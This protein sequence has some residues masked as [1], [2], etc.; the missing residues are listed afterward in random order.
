MLFLLSAFPFVVLFL[1]F[2]MLRRLTQDSVASTMVTAGVI[3][4]CLTLI[5]TELL[6]ALGLVVQGP[7]AVSWSIVLL[8]LLWAIRAQPPATVSQ[9]RSPWSSIQVK[10]LNA[11]GFEKCASIALLTLVSA[12]GL[13]ALWVAPNNHDGLAYHLPKIMHWIQNGNVNHYPTHIP[14]QIYLSPLAEYLALQFIVI[15]SHDYFVNSIQWLAYVGTLI[16]VWELSTLLGGRRFEKQIAMVLAATMPMGILQSTTPQNDLVVSFFF[17]AFIVFGLRVVFK[18]ETENKAFLFSVLTGASLGCAILTKSTAYIFAAPFVSYFCVLMVRRHSR[19]VALSCLGLAAVTVLLVNGVNYTRLYETYGTP[20]G[21][22]AEPPDAYFPEAPIRLEIEGPSTIISSVLKNLSI[23]QIL[24]WSEPQD[25]EET[26]RRLHSLIHQDPDR[27]GTNL[28]RKHGYD[29]HDFRWNDENFAGNPL[30]VLCAFLACL[31]Y[32]RCRF[33]PQEQEAIKREDKDRSFLFLLLLSMGFLLFCCLINWQPVASRLHLPLFLVAAA[34]VPVLAGGR[35]GG[36]SRALGHAVAVILL[37]QAIPYI[38]YNNKHKAV[39]IDENSLTLFD[40]S[41]YL[42]NS[43][44]KQSYNAIIQ[45]LISSDCRE[46][47]LMS[48]RDE[49]EYLL[50]VPV[51]EAQIDLRIEHIRVSNKSEMHRA[52]LAPFQPCAIVHLALQGQDSFRIEWLGSGP[53]TDVGL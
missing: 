47:G 31:I 44:V 20:L 40:R 18:N 52:R 36:K 10:W 4:S 35:Q 5:L 37:L 11:D 46:V 13:I 7:I 39:G 27:L 6:S 22:T 12:L 32:F 9:T 8:L 19:K 43:Q 1:I 24:P 15:G 16:G 14:R 3:W 45:K 53:G 2:V 48:G 50:W 34:P 29:L 21:P 42:E 33:T 30:F 49:M 51:L 26:V 23:H 25:V 17:I 41:Y 38:V 28:S